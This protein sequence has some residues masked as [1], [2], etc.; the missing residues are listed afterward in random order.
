MTL[1]M[2]QAS[3]P[4]FIRMLTNLAGVLAK[5]AAH[6]EAK[7]IDPAVLVNGRLFP[8]MFPLARQV[9]IVTDNAKGGAAR[10]AGLEPPK[11]EDNESS[12]PELMARI[13]KTVA[14]LKT[15]TPG[16]VDGSEERT[17]TLKLGKETMTF[18]GM[19]YLLN[20]VLPNI[21]FHSVTAYNILRHNGVD[22][23]KKDYLGSP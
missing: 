18:Q 17:I 19:P 23:G 21:Y 1:S 11:Y 2:Y 5:G 9:M 14:Y 7:K 20:L 13:D 16:Q 15:F 8:D 4:S 12:F 6:A 22:V 3:V 10:L